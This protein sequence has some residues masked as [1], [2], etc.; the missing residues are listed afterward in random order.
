MELDVTAV[1]RGEADIVSACA[2]PLKACRLKSP[3]EKALNNMFPGVSVIN[4]AKVN[5]AMPTDTTYEQYM[6]MS[7][8]MLDMCDTIYMMQGWEQSNGAKKEIIKSKELGLKILYQVIEED[9]I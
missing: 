4:P 5:A 1:R 2:P 9:K 8:T 3:A 7:F 6:A